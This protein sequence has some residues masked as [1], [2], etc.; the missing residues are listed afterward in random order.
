M[1]W[2]DP[3]PITAAPEDNSKSVTVIETKDETPTIPSIRL[4][5]PVGE[6]FQ[7]SPAMKLMLDVVEGRDWHLRLSE[8]ISAFIRHPASTD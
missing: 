8:R 4:T 6:S 3:Q 2:L 5:K 7:V 1:G